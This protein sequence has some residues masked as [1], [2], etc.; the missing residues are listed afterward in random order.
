MNDSPEDFEEFEDNDIAIVGMAGRFPGAT[1]IQQYWENLKGA[2]ESITELDDATLRRQGISQRIIDDPNYVKSGMFLEDFDQFDHAF[3]NFSPKDASILDPQH[4][5]FLEV[6]WEALED[7]GYD[8]DR[9]DGS[10][11]VFGGS[12]HNAYMP[13]NLLTNQK[14][15]DS[16]GLFL[17]RHTGNDKDFLTTR[18]SYNFN[19][20][21][22]S[23]NVQTAC[24]T[25]LVAAHMGIQSLLNGECDMALAGGVT[26][27]MPHRE[28]YMYKE[29]E[30][31]SPDGHCKPFE[32]TSKGTVFGSGVG[33]IVLKRLEDAL[34][35]GDNIHAV[36]KS[37]AINNDGL[38]KVSYLAPSVD[39]QA[40]AIK[41]ALDVA[42]IC[43]ETIQFV[44]CH[45]TGTP[46][47]D[48]IEVT[49]LTQA[50][51]TKTQKKQY[52]ALGS[53]KSNIGH[54]DTAA[55]VASMIKM[56]CGLKN[57]QM[58]ATLHFKDPN[59]SI[60]FESSPF[61]VNAELKKWPENGQVP[62]RAGVSSLGVGG[63]NAHIILEEAD[64]RDASDEP[65]RKNQLVV[66]SARSEKALDHMSQ[67]IAHFIQSNSE[68][69]LADIAFTLQE[70]RKPFEFRRVIASDSAS[71]LAEEL[72]NKDSD[73]VFSA[74]VTE[75]N[76]TV[77]FMFAGGGA[78]YPNMGRDLY[79]SEPLYKQIVDE[80]LGYLKGDI[81]FDLKAL[82]YP[83]A[84]QEEAAA[85]ELKKPSR[86]L[87]A[88]FA[89]QYAQ[90]KLWMSWG[91]EPTA[92]IGHSMGEY[93]AACLSGV[94]SVKDA[95]L[96][97]S[98]R[99]KL[100]ETL[101]EGA[102]LSVQ[103]S[104]DE[105]APHMTP[106]LSIAAANAPELT[107][108]S[109]PVAAIEALQE[110]LESQEL[111]C[112]RV[113][114]NVAAHSSML[115]PILE[116]FRE[117][118]SKLNYGEPS[119]PFI[120]NLS[121]TWATQEQVC[122]PNYWV[123]HLRQTVQFANGV[124]ELV[125]DSDRVLLEV[126]PGRT[127]AS[128]SRMH[129]EKSANQVILTSIKHYE[130]TCSDVDFML[131]MFGA[132]WTA[133]V[134]TDWSKLRAEEEY[135]HRISLPTYPFEHTRHWVEAGE[136]SLNQQDPLDKKDD[137]ADWYYQPVWKRA[138]LPH[139]QKALDKQK[140]LIMAGRHQ[141]AD[142]FAKA[143][144]GDAK[145]VIVVKAASEYRKLSGSEF[146]M[147]WSQPDQYQK[148]VS[149]LKEDFPSIVIHALNLDAGDQY[150][151]PADAPFY[152]LLWLSQA[153]GNEDISRKIHLA[154]LTEGVHQVAGESELDPYKALTQGPATV[155]PQ[156]FPNIT[157]AQVD[158]QIPHNEEQLQRFI[159]ALVKEVCAKK[160]DPT[161]A[162]RGLSRFVRDFEATT[163]PP[164]VK[165]ETFKE[166][167]I[168]LITGGLGGLG[169]VMAEA[170]ATS[171][172]AK[173]A[174]IGRKGLPPKEEW[175]DLVA[176]GGA[177]GERISKI[178]HI[179]S[180]GSKVE[181]F[182]A[183]VGNEKQLQSA[184][185]NIER[186]WGPVNGI[187]HTAGVIDDELILLKDAN[188]TE[189]VF[190]PK[191]KG[192]VVLDEVFS[193]RPLDFMILFSST[194]SFAGL[195][196]QI[197][198]ASANAFIDTFAAR[199]EAMTGQKTVAIN[200]PA[201]QD[202]GMAAR[203]LSGGGELEG[204]PQNHPCLDVCVEDSSENTVYQTNYTV[205]DFWLLNEHKIAEGECLIPGTGYLELARCAIEAKM[206]QPGL[207]V[208]LKDLFFMVPFI[209]GEEE[210]K[211]LQTVLQPMGQGEFEFSMQSER[212]GEMQEHVRGVVAAID[213]AQPDALNISDID[214]RCSVR[215]EFYRDEDHPHLIFGPRW[216]N[217]ESIKIGQGEALVS[218]KLNDKF[219]ADLDDFKLH[220]GVMD[221]ATGCAQSLVDG[222][223]KETDFYVPVGY[224]SLKFKGQ[225]PQEL[226][227]HIRYRKNAEGS[228]DHDVAIYD[229]TITDRDGNVLVEIEE[230]TMKRVTAEQI[231]AQASVDDEKSPAEQ[232]LE[233]NIELGISPK[234]GA[235]AF[236]RV[237]EKANLPQLVVTTR[238]LNALLNEISAKPGESSQA[239]AS[240]EPFVEDDPKLFEIEAKLAE[241]PAMETVIVRDYG[242]GDEVHRVAFFVFDPEEDATVSELRKFARKCLDEA[243]IPQHFIEKDEF[244][245]DDDEEIDRYKLSDPFGPVDDFVA[246]ETDAEKIIAKIWQ[247]VLGVDRIGRHDNFFDVGGHSLLSI[248]V[249]TKLHK[250]V[251]VKLNQAIMVLQ[252]LEQI[253]KDVEE[254]RG[255][256]AAPLSAGDAPEDKLS[257]VS[258]NTSAGGASSE[259]QEGNG[260]LVV[261]TADAGG[262]P[263][264]PAMAKPAAFVKTSAFNKSVDA[265]S[266]LESQAVTTLNRETESSPSQQGEAD[267]AKRLLNKVFGRK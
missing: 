82:L 149:D 182:S 142:D 21:G 64:A 203:M 129:P 186:L 239:N 146:Q 46:I 241:H 116:P 155:I 8:P 79:E 13:Y 87:P 136:G 58:P 70:G 69:P 148:L 90:A 121:G 11:G 190:A 147:D 240:A 134:D 135:R 217:I 6:S 198:Y 233:R 76:K 174:L 260:S 232:L 106:E 117:Y 53:V 40:G 92:M 256:Q 199:R 84:G 246:P 17:V 12:G 164:A 81:D 57:K 252:T 238:D 145:G 1:T 189:P 131:R 32:A 130:E 23:V 179:E 19:L 195:T 89:T 60:D 72:L 119:L 151:N 41:E 225:L 52:C 4:R 209:V 42:D 133:G 257:G 178:R 207:A 138:A 184:K 165:P 211:G 99:G 122:Q 196:G 137:P 65:L 67:N 126:G 219:V 235:E 173:I 25:S 243:D 215:E 143:L 191:V 162:Y 77:S 39:G 181:V 234:D 251:G 108:A 172:N 115:E 118:L 97:V 93:T 244:P 113:H 45:G 66:L 20:K 264:P 187:I 227:S 5:H 49:A 250:K 63:T 124:S 61:F 36:I 114:I 28:G 78:Q 127:L 95:I 73:E 43:P 51:R 177:Q 123:D 37:S 150:R 125:K 192:T 74:Q 15:M 22:P 83:P 14:I 161:V 226:F 34:E 30:I 210:T 154:V 7:A 158:V 168:Y 208:E 96:L 259:T 245:L 175:D 140:I 56:I 47:G 231:A 171:V 44:E 167:A 228:H 262:I 166:G 112:Q 33:V 247:E 224:T 183:D 152:S 101:D 85:V 31:L 200:W 222:Y 261:Q 141:I 248:R 169:L 35:D 153:L 218:L 229:V 258:S 163:L 267:I 54:L 176:K 2:K 197:D 103:L 144:R 18:V 139:Q 216:K 212:N 75:G 205:K 202:V 221:M 94:F 24:S 48:P 86:A 188:T 107:V 180:L 62:R 242:R 265:S 204:K 156:E 26:I 102:M 236:L 254:K 16:T 3:F 132:L 220:P 160:P 104:L 55:G 193:D 253:A 263:M 9:F 10:I 29:G 71:H 38:G 80:C 249:I 68:I 237:V 120:S 50:Y 128:L 110:R 59:P 100:F 230:F 206:S 266:M 170:I 109:G 91:I 213:F 214:A 185:E 98:L 157:A 255:P 105:L 27:N 223:N 194:S 88:L 159:Q 201:W 111:P